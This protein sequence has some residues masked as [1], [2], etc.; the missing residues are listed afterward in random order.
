M[1]KCG[2]W[3]KQMG[4]TKDQKQIIKQLKQESKRTINLNKQKLNKW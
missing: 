1:V 4:K 2:S 3:M